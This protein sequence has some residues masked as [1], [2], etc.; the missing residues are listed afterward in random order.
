MARSTLA[1]LTFFAVAASFSAAADKAAT[2]TAA[3]KTGARTT[4]ATSS[5]TPTKSANRPETR[6]KLS[7]AQIVEKNAAARGGLEAWRSVQTVSLMGKMEAGGNNRP[8]MPVPGVKAGRQMPRSRPAEQAQLPFIMELK[9]PNKVRVELQFNG[10]TA[11][12]V[13][14]GSNG[15]KV[16]PFLN[17]REVE[18]YTAEEMKAASTQAELDGYLIDYATKG[19]KIDLAGMEKVEDRDTY[20]LELTLKTGQK[21]HAWIDAET[22][23]EAK[24]EGTPRR[25][26]GKYHPVEIYFRDFRSINGIVF[27]YLLETRVD[28]AMPGMKNPPMIAE[29]I[30]IEKVT[31]NSKLDDALFTKPQIETAGETKTTAR[32]GGHSLP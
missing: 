12:Q 4:A 27:P 2:S 31:V 22:F 15:W 8:T 30:Y 14:D 32:T 21:I 20:K 18:P 5:V 9:R 1:T 16:R 24:I 23:L 13:F 11:L 17:R 3:A 7:A 26:D 29:K 28:D 6:I 25:L 10:Q 19:T